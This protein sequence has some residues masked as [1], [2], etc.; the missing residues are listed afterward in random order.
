M[1]FLSSTDW[2]PRTPGTAATFSDQADSAKEL[3]QQCSFDHLSLSL[4]LNVASRSSHSSFKLILRFILIAFITDHL[5]CSRI[6]GCSCLHMQAVFLSSPNHLSSCDG[7]VDGVIR[8]F[9]L[10]KCFF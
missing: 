3:S 5:L 6:Q 1:N 9:Q 2:S 4:I 8:V 7:Q 10:Y